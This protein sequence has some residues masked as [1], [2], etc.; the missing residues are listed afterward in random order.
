MTRSLPFRDHMIAAPLKRP[1]R[2]TVSTIPLTFRDH[3][4]A[5]PLKPGRWIINE[6]DRRFPRSHDR[7]SIEA[8]SIP[9]CSAR[10]AAFPRSHDRG[11]IEALSALVISA[12]TC[13]LSAIT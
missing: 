3:M 5:A 7:G 2:L 12:R 8:K 4:I 13:I 10:N 1:L 9:P 11:S 6:A